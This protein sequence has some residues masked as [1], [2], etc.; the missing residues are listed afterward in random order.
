[1]PVVAES[2]QPTR[3]SRM[4]LVRRAAVLVEIIVVQL[5]EERA[6][7]KAKELVHPSDCTIPRTARN[8]KSKG[9]HTDWMHGCRGGLL[10]TAT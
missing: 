10:G 6:A 2:E 4:N 9:P 1:V 7:T 3:L 8:E 5:S